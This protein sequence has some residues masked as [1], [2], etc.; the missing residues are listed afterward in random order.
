MPI[1]RGSAAR[2]SQSA[3]R[4]PGLTAHRLALTAYRPGLAEYRDSV[5]HTGA[6]LCSIVIAPVPG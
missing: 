6:A 1:R 3:R 4:W 2:G 5:G